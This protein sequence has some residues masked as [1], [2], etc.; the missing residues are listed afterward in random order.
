[1]EF[2][3]I[4]AEEFNLKLE[5]AT[6]V[7]NLIEEGN[8]IPFIAR[9][10]KEMH[11][12]CDDQVL[13]AFADRLTYLQNL[14]KRKNEVA[15]NITEQGKMTEEIT[16]ALANAT[17]LTEVEDIYRPFKQKKRTRASVAKERGLEPLSQI[18]FE[19]Q[20]DGD[21]YAEAE[22]YIDEEKGVK[23]AQDAVNGACDIIAEIISD[24][25]EMRKVLREFIKENAEIK[26]KLLDHPDNKTYD[27]YTEYSEKIA[28]I[29][30]HRV[31]A[32]NR[33]EKE[34]CLKVWIE[35]DE[36]IALNKVKAKYVRQAAP[37]A[38]KELMEATCI[39]AYK[40]LIFPSLEREARSELTEIGRAHV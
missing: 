23:T 19:Q 12:N 2:N 13:R 3:K 22:K 24:D 15:A 38:L 18:I 36:E 5:H 32:I 10:R 28:K 40:R 26:T 34:D 25:A 29:P 8:T 6:N 39:D 1:M 17:T 11:G 21:I 37:V 27:M 33:G 30:S 4:L 7:I 16:V 20:F 14:D 31:L 9:Y 35:A